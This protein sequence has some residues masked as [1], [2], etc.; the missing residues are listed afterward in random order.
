MAAPRSKKDQARLVRWLRDLGYGQ[1]EREDSQ[2]FPRRFHPVAEHIRAFDPDVALIVGERGT[3]KSAL[4]RAVFENGLL[5]ALARHARDPRL[6]SGAP[7]RI[8]W[9]QAYPLRRFPDPLGLRRCLGDKDPERALRLW[10]AYL[11]RALEGHLEDGADAE[12]RKLWELPGGAPQQVLEAFDAAADAPLLALDRLDEKLLREDRWLFAG[13]DE[14]DTLGGYDWQAMRQALL[15]L[16]GFWA[17][18]TR[19]WRRLRVK[20]FL[21]TDLFRRHTHFGGADLAKLASNR[22]ELTWSN[23]NLFAMLIK[24]IA[25]THDELLSYCRGGKISFTAEDP[26][27]GYVPQLEVDREARP[28]IE[29][30]AGP[31]MGRNPKKGRTFSWLLAHLSDAHGHVA[32]RNLVRLF[33]QAAT[34][35]QVNQKVRA[36]RLFHPTAFRQALEDVSADHVQ[37]G[38]SHEWPWLHG[39]EMRIQGRLMPMKRG[40]LQ[41]LLSADWEATW[42]SGKNIRPP[43]D[44]TT[45]LVDYLLELGVVRER[46]QKRVDLPDIYLFGLGLKRKGGVRKR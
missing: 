24:R 11:V 32:P 33:E 27:L 13:Y 41:E 20:L 3:G 43:V 36:P 38:A 9:I 37:Q 10:F 5:T 16:I 26:E 25:N 14:L 7:D 15:G 31:F 18:Y 46:P 42:G 2:A 44:S 29:R 22:A 4:F 19:R 35:E 30:M 23:R 6:P 21:R 28:L 40:E 17:S 34:K 1:A 45:E 39:V 8:S 12:L